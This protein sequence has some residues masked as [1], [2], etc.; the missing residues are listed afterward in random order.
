MEEK[1]VK[2]VENNAPHCS[3]F[4]K[5]KNRFCHLALTKSTD[6]FCSQHQMEN[7]QLC[8]YDPGHIIRATRMNQHIKCCPTKLFQDKQV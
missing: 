4:I 5:K 2:K 3:Y 7:K 8:P 6:E 1:K